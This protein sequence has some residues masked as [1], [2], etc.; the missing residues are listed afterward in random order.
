MTTGFTQRFM[1]RITTRIGGIFQN[2]VAS[3]ATFVNAGAPTNGTSGTL[4]GIATPGTHLIDTTNGVTYV[5]TGTSLSPV[6]TVGGSLPQSITNPVTAIGSTRAGAVALSTS[7]NVI[8]TAAAG[9]GAQLGAVTAIGV[10]GAQ[11]I[12]NNTAN[13]VKVYC[14]DGVTIDTVAGST[15][16][17]LSGTTAARFTVVSSTAVQSNLLGLKSA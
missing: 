13:A 1:G 8:A 11:I 2:G 9:T 14:A 5:N 15:G 7:L 17:T 4:A 6:W 16:V 10:G 12:Y 3:Q